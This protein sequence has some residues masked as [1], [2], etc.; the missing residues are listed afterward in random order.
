MQIVDINHIL[1]APDRQRQEIDA[2]SLTALARSIKDSQLLHAIVVREQATL[3]PES[4][5]GMPP[6]FVLVAGERRLRA[7]RHCHGLGWTV[8]HDGCTVPAGH[9]P[10]V[11]LGELD[12]LQAEEAELEENVKRKDLTWQERAAAEARLHN[13][14]S[15]QAGSA[16]RVQTVAATAQEVH[17]RSDGA[18]QDSVRTNILIAKHLSDPEV[19]KAATAKDAL[20][21]LKRREETAANVERAAVLGQRAA[22]DL[23]LCLNT[24]SMHWMD[25]VHAAKGSDAVPRFDVILTDPPYG[26][27]AQDFSDSGGKVVKG[28]EAHVYDDSY[29]SWKRLML[30]F[31][32]RSFQVTKPDAHLY[33]FCDID[34]FSEL[35]TMLAQ[36]GWRV[37]R[38]PLIWV[39][40]QASRVPWPDY[41]P[42]RHYELI[43]YAVKGDRKV[44][45]IA[46]DVLTAD[47]DTNLGHGAQKPVDLYLQLLRRSARAG[48][49]VLD[50]FAGTGTIFPAAH[51]LKVLATGIELNP[52]YYAI[53]A[54]RLAKLV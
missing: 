40:P 13:L 7:V 43:C 20:K 18:F 37:H 54:G 12:G 35:R 23:H 53:A 8:R 47:P 28:A 45:V 10:V 11:T 21:I 2:E 9:I 34:R 4:P 39:K 32:H 27:D 17:G 46:P 16:G 30:E 52:A 24:D 3:N 26:I 14:R 36:V 5:V 25:T 19:A 48:D 49:S 38:T 29:E 15:L 33:A 6:T 42:R 1:I 22:S 50:P 44:N 31:T 51:E 41:G